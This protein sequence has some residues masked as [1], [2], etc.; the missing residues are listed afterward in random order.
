MK[1]RKYIVERAV[2]GARKSKDVDYTSMFYM[3]VVIVTML[4]ACIMEGLLCGV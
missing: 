1:E 3:G 2:G 4:I